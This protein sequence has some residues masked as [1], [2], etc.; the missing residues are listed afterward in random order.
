MADMP[1]DDIRTEFSPL[2]VHR[3]S[4]DLAMVSGEWRR[5]ERGE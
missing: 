1:P 4:D 5:E 3:L 2:S